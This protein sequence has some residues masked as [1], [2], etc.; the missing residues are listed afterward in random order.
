MVSINNIQ[1]SLTIDECDIGWRSTTYGSYKQYIQRSLTIDVCDIGWRTTT[2]GS[3]KQY[4]QRSLTINECDIGRRKTTYGSYKQYSEN[5][6]LRPLQGETIP[7]VRP[8]LQEHGPT[9]RSF[10]IG[11]HDMQWRTIWYG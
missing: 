6:V 4:I 8:L 5:C 9:F 11:E 1:G 2:Y 7:Y 10:T 3:Y